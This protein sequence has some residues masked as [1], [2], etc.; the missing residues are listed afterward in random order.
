[1]NQWKRTAELRDQVLESAPEK[2]S[3]LPL[4]IMGALLGFLI[5]FWGFQGSNFDLIRLF[6]EWPNIQSRLSEM[7]PPE[8]DKLGVPSDYTLT[9]KLYNTLQN[10]DQN[11]DKL[12]DNK[13][14]YNA[15]LAST[16]S[17]KAELGQLQQ[18]IL[19]KM[20]SLQ[21]GSSELKNLQKQLAPL[22]QDESF[23]SEARDPKREPIRI[24]RNGRVQ[25]LNF[26][27]TY[28]RPDNLSWKE[29]VL[30]LG[31]T[32]EQDN[33]RRKW[34]NNVFPNTIIGATI[35][36]IQIAL[37]G[38]V[39]AL[40][41]AFPLAFL[42]ASN[43]TPNRHVYTGIRFVINFVRTIPDLALGLLFV[44]GVGLGAFAG[45]L[46]VAVHTMSVL[47]KLLSESIE[48]ID[49]GVVE[50]VQATGANYYQTISFAVIP[51]MLPDLISF[52]L[53]R[54]ETNIRAASVLGLI[55]AGGIGQ[56]LLSSFRM[57]NYQEALTIVL[58]LTLLVMI[59]DWISA[60]L[61]NWVI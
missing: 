5:V 2:K 48:N 58:V 25:I 34:F 18:P 17:Y 8:L 49:S 60:R 19:D 11:Q 4:K 14:E 6:Q 40:V 38:T 54:F 47:A 21:S 26:D 45:T 29:L 46:A 41:V 53:Y 12:I 55:G 32:A 15:F 24:R 31:L 36:T 52:T 22:L 35:Q 1:M 56:I 10:A 44:S 27:S 37:T 57:F 50:A 61:R 39:V 30:P 20:E 3:K 51:Q 42:A 16:E 7:W 9:Q 59:V 23:L 28:N 33:S 13:E 43:T